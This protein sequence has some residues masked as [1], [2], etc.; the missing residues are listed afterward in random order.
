MNTPAKLAAYGAALALVAGGAWGVGAAVGPLRAEPAASGPAAGHGDDHAATGSADD[1]HGDGAGD[2]HSDA[3]PAGLASSEGGYTLVPATTTLPAGTTTTFAFRITGRDGAAVTG[4][5]VAHDKRMHLVVVR[6]DTTG[7]QHV[8]P[9]MAAD[10]TWSVPLT[11]PEAG[12][13]RVFADFAPTGGRP[14]TLGADISVPGPFEPRAHQPSW[15]AEVDGYQVRLT[16]R[17]SAGHVAPVRLTV[18]KD[19]GPVTDLEPYLGSYGH[20]VVLR[21]GDLGYLHVHPGQGAAGPE[22]P[23][24]VEVPTAGTYR[25][26]LDFQHAGVVRTA[27]F[28]VE[29]GRDH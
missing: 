16:G 20:L 6:R 13:Y 5:D 21:E 18:A 11:L 22:I 7:F 10:G 12:S 25:L 26:F 19:G 9:D 28:T 27:E 17:L 23:F 24:G 15:T 14:T 8:H 2:G 4:F 1:G 3:P 29:V